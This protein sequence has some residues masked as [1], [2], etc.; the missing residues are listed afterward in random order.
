MEPKVKGQ[1]RRKT[2]Q[3]EDGTECGETGAAGAATPDELGAHVSTAGG[4]RNA[5]GRAA[6]LDSAV[7][8]LFTKQPSRWAE[9]EITSE[10]A[11]EFVEQRT[12]HAI[13]IA[14]AH[15]SY[16]INLASADQPLFRRSLD[17]FIGELQRCQR[18]GLEFLVTHPGNATS[19]DVDSSLDRNA[20]AI[21]E[22]LSLVPGPLQ[23]LLETTAGSGSA[24]GCTF[25]QLSALINRV[26]DPMRSRLGVCLDTCHVFAAGYDLR[27]RYD[28][29]IDRFADVI[30]LERLRL[31]HLNDSVG[32]L[33][34]RRD[35]HAGIG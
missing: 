34:S 29:V 16:L 28:E 13:K 11:D 10:V 20:A 5:P 31:F 6:L 27:D 17:C 9:P 24:L 32:T 33:G 2:G 22:A 14:G 1:N 35:R 18:L 23:V 12:Q 3:V 4:V 30:G 26:A 8:Q 7:L 21:E 15:D 19:G 25:E